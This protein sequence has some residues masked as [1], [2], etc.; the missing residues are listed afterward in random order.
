MQRTREN[1]EKGN[2]GRERG[3]AFSCFTGLVSQHENLN[4]SWALFFAQLMLA[5]AGR[6][7]TSKV[8][9][10]VHKW[11]KCLDSQLIVD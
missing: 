8:L 5:F 9:P 2:G 1:R 6:R 4:S 7:T 3:Y 11:V 10:E